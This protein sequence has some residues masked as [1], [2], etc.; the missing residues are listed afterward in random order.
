MYTNRR[1]LLNYYVDHPCIDCGETDP[2]LLKFDHVLGKNCSVAT[3]MNRTTW[4][5]VL[6][7]IALC[8]V[9]CVSCHTKITA[10]RGGYWYYKPEFADAV[11][12]YDG[13]KD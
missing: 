6:A 10:W 13:P 3:L 1:N 4:D 9:R 2:V 12:A 8:V 11:P 7:E 5:K